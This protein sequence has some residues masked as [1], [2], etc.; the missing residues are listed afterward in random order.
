MPI[1]EHF[2]KNNLKFVQYIK[3]T[4][5]AS[6]LYRINFGIQFAYGMGFGLKVNGCVGILSGGGWCALAGTYYSSKRAMF[7]VAPQGNTKQGT[8]NTD[9]NNSVYNNSTAYNCYTGMHT[10]EYKRISNS[11]TGHYFDNNLIRQLTNFTPDDNDGS[12]I[13]F[14]PHAERIETELMG[15]WIYDSSGTKILDAVPA[16]CSGVGCMYDVINNDLYFNE[17]S[18]TFIIGPEL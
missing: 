11:I 7:F 4:N 6:G 17:L 1:R 5:T 2:S 3:T 14:M 12:K 10:I 8:V 13:R 16:S 9:W 18:G 15:F